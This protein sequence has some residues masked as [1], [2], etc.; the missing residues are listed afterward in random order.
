MSPS[1]CGL[2]ILQ[3]TQFSGVTGAENEEIVSFQI[4]DLSD[5]F[6]SPGTQKVRPFN[7]RGS[8]ECHEQCPKDWNENL[9]P[10]QYFGPFSTGSKKIQIVP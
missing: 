1:I 9:L 4:N 6:F 8:T 7:N 3:K 5:S 10:Y 2:I